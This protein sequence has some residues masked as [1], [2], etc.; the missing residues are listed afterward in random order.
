MNQKCF[1]LVHYYSI[2][3]INCYKHFVLNVISNYINCLF[4]IVF[5]FL[6]MFV[7]ASL[8]AKYCV[9]YFSLFLLMQCDMSL[10]RFVRFRNC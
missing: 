9:N 2:N 6:S 1:D 4:D 5:V 10:S 8:R 3:C 7:F